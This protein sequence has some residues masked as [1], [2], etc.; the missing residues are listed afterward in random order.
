MSH[1]DLKVVMRYLER[2]REDPD[3]LWGFFDEDVEWDIGRG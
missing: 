3:A 2:A 1:E